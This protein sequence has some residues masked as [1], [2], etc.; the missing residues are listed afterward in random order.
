MIKEIKYSG[1]TATPSDYECPDGDLAAAINIIPEEGALKTIEK[2]TV[3][4]SLDNGDVLMYIHV[5]DDNIKNYII[6][7]GL[8]LYYKQGGVG[9]KKPIHTFDSD[10]YKCSSNGNVLCVYGAGEC[11]HFLYADGTYSVFASDDM[12]VGILFGLDGS[13]VQT[14]SWVY[15]VVVANGAYTASRWDNYAN[16]AVH[17][18]SNRSGSVQAI[19]NIPPGRYRFMV[20][21]DSGEHETGEHFYVYLRPQANSSSGSVLIKYNGEPLLAGTVVEYDVSFNVAAISVNA[22]VPVGIGGFKMIYEDYDL[23][24]VIDKLV[25]YVTGDGSGDTLSDNHDALASVMGVANSLVNSI[26]ANNRFLFP[27]FVRYGFRLLSGEIITVS[28]PILMEPNTMGVPEICINQ[29]GPI[30]QDVAGG[31]KDANVTALAY[32]CKLQYKVRDAEKLK[33]LI[34]QKKVSSLVIAVSSPIYLYK[35]SS[36]DN[37]IR[38]SVV[39][40]SSRNI[41]R[42]YAISGV[43]EFNNSGY[44]M[45]VMLP[46]NGVSDN[47]EANLANSLGVFRIIKEIDAQDISFS[48]SFVDV[49]L[50]AGVISGLSGIQSTLGQSISNLN[51]YDYKYVVS[52]N[53][54]EHASGISEISFGGY[55]LDCMSGYVNGDNRVTNFSVVRTK[56]DESVMVY[57]GARNE[58]SSNRRWFFYPYKIS[59]SAEIYEGTNKYTVGLK[60]CNAITGMYHFGGFGLPAQVDGS[61][62][63]T[64]KT[65]FAKSLDNTLYISKVADPTVRDQS[66]RVG[67]GII[68]A[69]APSTKPVSRGQMGQAPLFVFATDGI[70]VLEL[71]TDGRYLSR[72]ALSRDVCTNIESITSI[73]DGLLYVCEDMIRLLSNSDRDSVCISDGICS[74]DMFVSTALPNLDNLDDDVVIV[75]ECFVQFKTFLKEAKMLYEYTHQRIIVYNHLYDYAYV[76]SLKSK[77]WG[78]M[79][80][81]IQYGINSYPECLVVTSD[82]KILN[83]SIEADASQSSGSETAPESGSG[84]AGGGSNLSD[85]VFPE[86]ESEWSGEEESDP[87][88]T[89]EYEVTEGE[90]ETS[91]EETETQTIKGLLITRPLKLGA[92]DLLKTVDTIIQRGKFEK[93]H[94]KTILYG[95]RDLFNWHL[96]YSSTDHYLRGFRGTPYKYFRIVLLCD[97][98]KDESIFGCTVQYTP[99]LLDQPR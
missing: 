71:M 36:T 1:Y 63:N 2:G 61:L 95:S 76:Y 93:G 90:T 82:N 54:R 28:A 30:K 14:N 9:T 70:W 52:Y 75:S 31:Y 43:K 45:Y 15:N 67:D 20:R 49:P 77:R 11:I 4:G 96:V 47:Y 78:M 81:N 8:S 13:L 85:E 72:Q 73:D 23:T 99:R 25:S 10:S 55:D 41:N 51:T 32:S 5:V 39:T 50:D 40:S 74:D 57:R 89:Q 17:L 21:N 24:I 69:I 58:S 84:G 59:G 26:H 53:M 98:A 64:P 87:E 68:L 62:A 42:C 91:T 83:L 97:L 12:N 22:G 34:A 19:I 33:S 3:I 46:D 16:V 66:L 56:G 7:N 86:D 35:Q 44:S 18:P 29:I 60:D 38:N 27:F 88:E 48:D 92:P 65:N 79:E 80:S 37:E 94:V 6:R